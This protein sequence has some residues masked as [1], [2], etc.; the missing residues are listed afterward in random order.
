MRGFHKLPFS[1]AT[2]LHV[3]VLRG[4]NV[5]EMKCNLKRLFVLI[6]ATWIVT[7]NVVIHSMHNHA[8]FGC[9]AKPCVSAKPLCCHSLKRCDSCQTGILVTSSVRDIQPQHHGKCLACHYLSQCRSVPLDIQITLIIEFLC[10]G[11][12]FCC[13]PLFYKLFAYQPSLPRGP[14]II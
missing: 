7:L 6:L 8:L 12:C 1:V 13:Q 3:L 14:P 9:H 11:T 4:Q 2:Q 10:L 5:S